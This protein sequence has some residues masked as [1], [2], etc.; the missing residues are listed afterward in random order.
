MEKASGTSIFT[1]FFDELLLYSGQYAIFYILMNFSQDGLGYFSN[2]GH[3]MLLFILIAQTVFLALYGGKPL[4]RLLGS[5][6]APIVYTLLESREGLDF[7]FNT[8]HIF[9][10]VFSIIT[11]LLQSTSLDAKNLLVR[12]V[13]EFVITS[14]NVMIF[15]FIYFYFDLK[16]SVGEEV[17]MGRMTEKAAQNSLQIGNIFPAIRAFF[18]D[19]SHVYTVLGGLFLSV[20]LSV[21]RAKIVALKDRLNDLF[22]S[23]VDKNIRDRIVSSQGERSEHKRLC[24]LFADIKNFTPTTE[25]A[26]AEQV[27]GML[28]TIFS[29]WND[30]VRSHRGVIDK[31]IG[32]AIMVI[33]GLEKTGNASADAVG[34]A[35]EMIAALP[36]LKKKLS[37]ARFPVLEDIRIGINLGEVVLGDI[38]SPERRNYT[39]VGDAVN[40]AARLETFCKA[41]GTRLMISGGTFENLGESIKMLFSSLGQAILKGK[42]ETVAVYALRLET[43]KLGGKKD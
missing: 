1:R 7:I 24:I 25:K 21:G 28:N 22:G 6:I 10:W 34:C 3:T 19:D 2:L 15:L 11:G 41:H 9:F 23:Y 30:I 18:K 43:P 37:A 14:I 35:L 16:L 38:G 4:P 32:D 29:Q 17:A 26:D 5:L 8:A 40:I 13:L 42:D 27:T 36:D 39:V 31:F 33:F 12:Q 20:S